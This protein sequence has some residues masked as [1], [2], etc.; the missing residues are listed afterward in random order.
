MLEAS[1]HD[2]SVKKASLPVV[3]LIG[4]AYGD[5]RPCCIG[6]LQGWLCKRMFHAGR[7][8]GPEERPLTVW[9]LTWLTLTAE[10]WS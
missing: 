4:R 3:F 9:R 6:G 8:S 1:T 5:R 10:L 2:T 7:C